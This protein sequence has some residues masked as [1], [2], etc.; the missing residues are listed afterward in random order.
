M[1]TGL[2]GEGGRYDMIFQVAERLLRVQCK[3]APLHGGVIAFR[4]YSSR[5]NRQGV[6]RKNLRGW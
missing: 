3:W 4:C 1:Y 6:V 2:S 5:R